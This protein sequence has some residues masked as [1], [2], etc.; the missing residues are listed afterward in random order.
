LRCCPGILKENNKVKDFHINISKKKREKTIEKDVFKR[1]NG[2]SAC[3]GKIQFK[4]IIFC[5]SNIPQSN[6][7]R[8]SKIF[9]I[10][11]AAYPDRLQVKKKR[12]SMKP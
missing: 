2:L 8:I 7:K 6:E 3:L 1:M 5:A 12:E 11:T 9:K 4:L 10:N